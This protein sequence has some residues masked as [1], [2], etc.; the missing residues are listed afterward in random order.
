MDGFSRDFF[1]ESISRVC[2]CRPKLNLEIADAIERGSRRILLVGAC[3]SGKTRLARAIL[4]TIFQKYTTVTQIDGYGVSERDSIKHITQQMQSNEVLLEELSDFSMSMT[5]RDKRLTFC[6]AHLIQKCNFLV[7]TTREPSAVDPSILSS[8]TDQFLLTPPD[9]DGRLQFFNTL[10]DE[11]DCG[12]IRQYRECQTDEDR[13]FLL[14]QYSGLQPSELLSAEM[15]VP[16]SGF[17]EVA[18]VDD[19]LEKI[20]FLVL[21]PLTDPQI[22]RNI[23]ARP[24]RGVLLTGAPGCGKSLIARSIGKASKSSFFDICGTE[25][26]AKE[27]GESEK[28]LH[29]IFERARA[30]APSIILFDDIDAIAPKRTFGTTNSEAGDRI[31]TTLL[32]EM[33]GL[34][35]RDDGVVVIATTSRI[36]SLDPAIIRP[37]RFDHIID[38]PLPSDKARGEIF[39]LY[40]RNVPLADKDQIRNLVVQATAGLTGANIEGIVREAAMITLR[41]DMQSQAV[42]AEAVKEAISSNV[43]S[44]PKPVQFAIS[45][46]FAAQQKKP[47]NKKVGFGSQRK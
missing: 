28:R 41:K 45:K 42:T 5:P 46:G 6:I 40:T 36:T 31:L 44:T 12:L 30:A 2:C 20:K 35:G 8:F 4:S 11:Y 38:I 19:L 16:T 27:V 18:G 37:G 24:P 22:F 10:G 26:I 3:G 32:V 34:G 14:K 23:G 7:A 47:L 15:F 13:V 17:S 29:A 39:D 43:K 21:K 33:D 25:I 1:V 9:L